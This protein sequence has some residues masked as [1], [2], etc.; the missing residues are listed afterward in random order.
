MTVAAYADLG[1]GIVTEGAK[2]LDAEGIP[3]ELELL[4]TFFGLDVRLYIRNENKRAWQRAWGTF[5]MG[6]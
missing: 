5:D 6:V 4:E 3:T 1:K 2:E